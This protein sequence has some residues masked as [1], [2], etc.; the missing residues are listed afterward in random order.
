MLRGPSLVF[1]LVNA[2]VRRLV[3]RGDLAG[4][5][6][7]EAVPELGE[8]GLWATFERVYETGERF[9]GRELRV[10]IEQPGGAPPLAGYFNLVAQPT[11]GEGGAID[12]VFVFAVE[13]TDL[14]VARER[15]AAARALAEEGRAERAR[16]LESERRARAEAERSNR[17]KDEFLAIVS[18]ELRTPL[19]A[20]LGWTRLLRTSA[21]PED[22][23]DRAL[24]TIERNAVNQAQ[25]IEDLLDVSRITSGK[26][27]LETQRVEL[28]RAAEAAVESARPAAE[29]KHIAMTVDPGARGEGVIGDATR[30]QQIVWNLLTNAVKFT[31]QGGAI[32]VAIAR[33][34][35]DLALSVSDDGQ[36]LDPGFLP[37]VF[38]PFRQ[39]DGSTTRAH[40]GL[41]LGLS[42]ARNLV[43]MHGGTI[44]AESAG[45]GRGA[46][47][48]VRLPAAPPPEPRTS[49][50]LQALGGGALAG[51]ARELAGLRVLVVDDE[52]DAREL[53][54][55]LLEDQGAEVAVAASAAEALARILAAAPDVLVTDI[56]MPG[57]DGYSLIRRVREQGGA[58]PAASLTA[59][60]SVDDR[61][62]ALIAGFNM[63]VSKP[64]E[65]TELV[66]A[67]AN[68]GRIA[69]AIH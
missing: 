53:V 39:Q 4:R 57:E 16:L 13:I 3:G 42:I 14:V 10:V 26:I 33:E 19:S 11:R 51:R 37:H 46:T 2:T 64:V 41:G 65:P 22:R 23:R 32:R 62:R 29:A 7:R 36:G 52:D 43:E 59:Y 44:A 56:G 9:E 61:R 25:L 31:P 60:A 40:G 21:L 17:V 20:V 5:P 30:L 34:G 47:F 49:P 12:G 24:E 35:G 66:A 18:H 6:G 38:E 69:R 54:R 15:E 48:T 68:L 1:E 27:R 55:T 58:T 50:R 63:H 45:P 28:A 8:Q 67:V